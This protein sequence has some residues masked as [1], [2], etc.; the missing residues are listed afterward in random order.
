MSAPAKREPNRAER[1]YAY[2][3]ARE[4]VYI[5]TFQLEKIAGRRAWRT[6]VSEC[7][8]F[9]AAKHGQD[10]VNQQRRK[11]IG[12]RTWTDSTYALVSVKRRKAA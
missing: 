1:I 4:G 2:L 7:R 9:I 5:D 3:S 11:R 12:T 10:I 6:A 8:R